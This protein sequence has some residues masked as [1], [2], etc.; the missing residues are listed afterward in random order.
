MLQVLNGRDKETSEIAA[1]HELLA[2]ALIGKAV[3]IEGDLQDPRAV[4]ALEKLLGGEAASATARAALAA[5][6][7]IEGEAAT[8]ALIRALPDPDLASE[9]AAHL[10]RRTSQN[11]GTDRLRWEAWW[12]RSSR[13]GGKLPPLQ[14]ALVSPRTSFAA[15][16]PVV[17]E[18]R[19]VNLGGNEVEFELEADPGRRVRVA[20]TAADASKES[21]PVRTVRLA[22]GEFVGGPIDLSSRLDKPGRRRIFW[23]APLRVDGKPAALE[24][25]PLVIDRA[26]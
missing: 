19:L 5:L 3:E 20:S 24:A 2:P 14:A 11:L 16:E 12:I 17:V 4:P 26:P 6:G 25:L 9:A 18:W 8:L 22:P 23:A 1:R 21:P 10:G 15:G 7:A 13:P